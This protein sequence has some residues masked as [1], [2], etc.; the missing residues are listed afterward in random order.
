MAKQRKIIVRGDQ[1][2]DI[3]TLELAKVL[4]ALAVEWDQPAPTVG[5]SPDAFEAAIEDRGGQES[6]A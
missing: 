2:H 4:I 3:D 5:G 1:R 6:D